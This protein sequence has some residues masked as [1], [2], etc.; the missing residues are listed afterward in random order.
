MRSMR[1]M[2]GVQFGLFVLVGAAGLAVTSGAKANGFEIPENGTDIM[3]RAGAWT[4]R[5]SPASPLR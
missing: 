2:G 4:A 1:S 3:G 5:A